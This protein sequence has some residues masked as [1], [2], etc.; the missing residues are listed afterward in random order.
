[1]TKLTI[2]TGNSKLGNIPNVSLPPGLTCRK[3]TPCFTCKTCYALRHAW[4]PYP[5]VRKAW[6]GNYNLWLKKPD[7]F[8]E[9]LWAWLNKH[10]PDRFRWH[11]GGDIPD[12]AY[13]Y[14]IARTAGYFP[15]IKFLCFTKKYEIVA[16]SQALVFPTNLNLVLSMWP[17]LDNPLKQRTFPRGWM[18]DPKSP[19]TRI[20]KDAT[21]CPGSCKTCSLC[22]D[23][24]P[25]ESVVFDKH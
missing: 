18:R 6:Q 14:T 13:L 25:R 7:E 21:T 22:W 4:I 12:I 1:M 9:Q 5:Q 11:V 17:G 16:D 24:K 3:N 10:K 20:P 8:R 19:D 23:L 2:S 15:G